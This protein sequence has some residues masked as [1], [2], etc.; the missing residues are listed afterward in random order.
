LAGKFQ[1]RSRF[2]GAWLTE[3]KQALTLVKNIDDLGARLK[4]MAGPIRVLQRHLHL[5]PHDITLFFNAQSDKDLVVQGLFQYA[6]H[7]RILHSLKHDLPVV[8][9]AR[10]ISTVFG[11]ALSWNVQGVFDP[12]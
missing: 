8:E 9:F 10:D 6:V 11:F 7:P 4:D 5:I 2:S 1:K 3:D 12:Q